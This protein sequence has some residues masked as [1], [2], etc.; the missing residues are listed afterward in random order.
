VLAEEGNPELSPEQRVLWLAR[1][2]V[3]MDNYRAALEWLFD[4]FDL[5]WALRLCM[6]LFR[7][8]D[9]RE[10]LTEGRAQLETALRLAGS[11]HPKE[12]AKICIF[13]GALST[14][15]GDFPAAQRFLEQ[16]LRLYEELQDNWGI[17]ASLNALG[18]SA[19]DRGD[20]YS[21]QVHLERS[22]ACWRTLS[23]QVSTA[24][25]LHNLANVAKVRGD[26]PRAQAALREA[27]TI[28]EQVGDRSGAA[29]SISQQGD[30]AREQADTVEARNMYQQALSIFTQAGDRWGAARALTDLGYICCELGEYD[31]A[32][33]AFRDAMEVF[34]DLGHRRGIARVLEGSACLAAGRG[35]AKRALRL[36]AAAAHLRGLIS[37]PLP[38]AEHANLDQNLQHARQS[39]SDAEGRSAW[40]EGSLMTI[41]KA[42]QYSL[43][44]SDNAT[45]SSPDR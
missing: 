35:S 41:E 21:A 44:Q 13:L 1:C 22:L 18:V 38:L 28:F 25:C 4:N 7:F 17:A 24:R 3:E 14:A 9:M 20:Y 31:A 12:K 15:Q 11:G 34:A 2:D 29:W 26:Y 39:L 37:A 19:R 23:D 40:E 43:E 16:S 27:T 33:D 6:A 10:H 32:H 8:W 42:I 36:A 30:I 45:S 5:D